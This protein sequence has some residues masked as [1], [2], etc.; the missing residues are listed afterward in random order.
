MGKS[1][2]SNSGI[3]RSSS[4][5]SSRVVVGVVGVVVVAQYQQ[6]VCCRHGYN[7]FRKEEQ[8]RLPPVI[9]TFQNPRSSFDI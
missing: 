1:S 5:I 3:S 4:S 7:D 8:H 6:S 2:R 9:S